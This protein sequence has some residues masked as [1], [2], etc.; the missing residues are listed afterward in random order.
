MLRLDSV[1]KYL[2]F[3]FPHQS[4]NLYVGF[5]NQLMLFHNKLLQFKLYKRNFLIR[6]SV[7]VY[8]PHITWTPRLV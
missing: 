1:R 6:I 4:L 2:Q 3:I 5:I 8:I 7:A